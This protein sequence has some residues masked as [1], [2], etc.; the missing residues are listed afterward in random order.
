MMRRAHL[1]PALTLPLLAAACGDGGADYPSLVPAETI[2]AEPALPADTAA[3]ATDPATAAAPVQSRADA[4][5][6]RAQDLRGPVIDP[7]TRARM[8]RAAAR[9]R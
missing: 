9:H 5:R 2:L 6:N 4:L 7:A 3:A 8:D 1:I